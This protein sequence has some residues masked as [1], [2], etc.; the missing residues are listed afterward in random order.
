MEPEY[1]TIV[2]SNGCRL[3][4]TAAANA[5]GGPWSMFDKALCVG[6]TYR[7]LMADRGISPYELG[8][9]SLVGPRSVPG[10]IVEGVDPL[11]DRRA[12]VLAGVLE[13]V[14]RV[15]C[16]EQHRPVAEAALRIEQLALQAIPEGTELTDP[17]P[18]PAFVKLS[19]KV[20][21]RGSTSESIQAASSPAATA[22][23]T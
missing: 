11:L 6:Y 2:N 21:P 1:K 17:D 4:L 13:Q 7:L 19:V 22:R 14:Q 20:P 12:L 18:V 16:L 8:P 10:P 9:W 3:A 23:I 15:A 5:S